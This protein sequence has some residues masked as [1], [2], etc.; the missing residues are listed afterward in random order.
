M[1]TLDTATI[2]NHAA[3]AIMDRIDELRSSSYSPHFCRKTEKF[4]G[5]TEIYEH[6]G[7][8]VISKSY[9]TRGGSLV[10]HFRLFG[11]SAEGYTRLFEAER[12]VSEDSTNYEILPNVFIDPFRLWHG[13]ATVPRFLDLAP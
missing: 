9:K 12:A 8:K 13:A 10:E 3:R 2:K 5:D 1:S 11:E 4:D 7:F 6:A